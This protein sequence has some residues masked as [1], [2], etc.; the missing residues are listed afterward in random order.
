MLKLRELLMCFNENEWVSVVCKCVSHGVFSVKEILEKNSD[1]LDMNVPKNG[2]EIYRDKA[3]EVVAEKST[4]RDE[5][6]QGDKE[7]SYMIIEVQD[8]E[9]KQIMKKNLK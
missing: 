8:D 5:F 2:I 3:D 6:F 7:I 1:I 9:K 4:T